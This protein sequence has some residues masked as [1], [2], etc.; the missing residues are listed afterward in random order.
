MSGQASLFDEEP[1]Y[2][3]DTNVIVSFLRQTED[4]YYG[5]DV[6]APQWQYIEQLIDARAIVAPLQVERELAKWA[7]TIAELREW[8][9]KRRH[10]FRD[11]VSDTQLALAKK[12]VNQYPIYGETDNYLGD[13]EVITL[14]G[15]LGIA[16]IS[17]EG[18][19]ENAGKR[20]PKIPNICREFGID[21]VSVSGFLRREGFGQAEGR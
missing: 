17:L 13:L 8:L 12:I 16:V 10:M 11:V 4:E 18:E 3:I 7:K 19:K 20:R 1:R 14:A 2:C 5:S 21:C 15:A 9:R 6:F